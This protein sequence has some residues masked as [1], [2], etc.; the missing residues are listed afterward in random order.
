MTQEAVV[1][2]PAVLRPAPARRRSWPLRELPGSCQVLVVV[3]CAAAVL[4]LVGT[5]ATTPWRVDDAALFAVLLTAAAVSVESVRRIPEPAGMNANDMLAAWCLPI[6]VLLPP[7][8][9]FVAA[10]A[11]MAHTQWRVRRIPLVK[12]FYSAAAIGLANAG[13]STVFAALPDSVSSAGRLADDGLA[14][15]LAVTGVGVLAKLV[16]LVLVGL[17]VG[18]AD[19]EARWRDVF[20][21]DDGRLEVAEVCAGVLVVLSAWYSPVVV[22]LALP[23]VLLLQ[24]GMLYAQLHTAART[25]AKTGLLN[26]VAWEREA[27]TSLVE[28]RRTARPVAVLLVDIDHFKRVNDT[29]GHLVGDDVLRA[30]AG[31]LRGQLRDDHDLLCRFGGEEF[32]VLLP[33]VDEPEAARAAE[34]LREAVADLVTPVDGSLV[35]VTVSVGLAV[36][37]PREGPDVPELLARADLG[38]YR[39]KDGGRNQVG[40]LVRPDRRAPTGER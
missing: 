39:A 32:A 40:V 11:L 7:V 3:V 1:P 26:A 22:A 28:A 36:A 34:R 31:V 19:P 13:A 12:R 38:L 20:V 15:V 33:G 9:S 25:D 37:D 30:V 16:N 24:R 18:T 14:V 6:A 21:V 17:A 35:Q 2:V 5:A 23:P 4:C 10:G 8:W 27:A 29:H